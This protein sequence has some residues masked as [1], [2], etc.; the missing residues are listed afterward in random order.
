MLKRYMFTITL[1]AWYSE[2]AKATKT[3]KCLAAPRI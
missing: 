1:Y 3:V 2:R